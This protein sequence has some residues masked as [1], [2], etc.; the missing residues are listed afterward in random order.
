M[1]Y[2][3]HLVD[4]VQLAVYA[5]L[6]LV[7]V[8]DV[9]FEDVADGVV[10][11][12][13]AAGLLDC[14]G[15]LGDVDE[16]EDGGED[17]VHALHV[18]DLAVEPRVDVEDAAHEVVAVRPALPLLL[19]QEPLV[20]QL[21][22]PVDQPELLL[23][24]ARQ[25]RQQHLPAGAREEGELGV[26]ARGVLLDL[27]PQQEVALQLAVPRVL[28]L[29]R[30]R[31]VLEPLR[32]QEQPHQSLVGLGLLLDGRLPLALL[33]RQV[34]QHD[35]PAV[36]SDDRGLVRNAHCEEGPEA[37]DVDGVGVEFLDDAGHLLGDDVGQSFGGEVGDE[38]EAGAGVG[39]PFVLAGWL[40]L[41][42]MIIAMRSLKLA[43]VDLDPLEVLV[44]HVLQLA[45][46]RLFPPLPAAP[47][48]R[49]RLHL[50]RLLERQLLPLRHCLRPLLRHLDPG[51]Q[52]QRVYAC[53]LAAFLL[54]RHSPLL[55]LLQRKRRKHAD[56]LLFGRLLGRLL[57]LVAEPLRLGRSHSLQVVVGGQRL[58]LP[59]LEGL[60]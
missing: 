60:V 5:V 11:H 57:V 36:L 3:E 59:V 54:L 42:H 21:V 2:H 40:L 8:L 47:E 12:E 29:Q 48:H 39:E 49:S 10:E 43:G 38:G 16:V 23:P 51:K 1:A 4:L 28:L 14:G 30:Q 53:Q 44:V 32:R 27:L 55:R 34:A 37:G 17:F 56:H 24:R 50:R 25:V 41:F 33:G 35:L 18:L 22:L 20:L 58:L 46:Q 26:R 9:E 31:V 7:E 6:A 45:D 13:E 52:V 15:G 19:Q